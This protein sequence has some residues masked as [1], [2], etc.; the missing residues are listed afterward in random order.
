LDTERRRRLLELLSDNDRLDLQEALLPLVAMYQECPLSFLVDPTWRNGVSVDPQGALGVVAGVVRQA[1]S[2]VEK[3]ATWIQAAVVYNAFVTGR[4]KV[5]KGSVLA[6][7]PEIQDY[8]ETDK[9]KLLASAVRASI[10][11]FFGAARGSAWSL[12]FWRHGFDISVCRYGEP[13]T[14]DAPDAEVLI[15]GLLASAQTY[16]EQLGSEL[17]E[18]WNMVTPDLA[19]PRRGEVL[20]ALLA[21]QARL[22]SAIVRDPHLWSVDIGR[23]TLRCMVDTYIT[24]RWLAEK[25]RAADFDSFVEHGL[26]NEKLLVEHLKAQLSAEVASEIESQIEH[27]E[28]WINSQLYTF[29]LPVNIG[30]WKSIRQMADEL[31]ALDIY[32]L[33]FAPYSANI[34]GTWNALARL[35]LRLCV[36]PLHGLHR[37]PVFDDPGLYLDTPSI[38]VDLM[39]R[40]FSSWAEAMGLQDTQLKPGNLFFERLAA[41]SEEGPQSG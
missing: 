2:R 25:G 17:E 19:E 18:Q 26:G 1:E 3:F 11:A 14:T 28:Q 29:L 6:E 27:M 34:H 5:A 32:N 15:E 7:F 13:N 12:Y 31:G 41:R 36:N 8:P 35:N 10:N 39:R 9:S 20:S 37:T 21:R 23:I 33:S 22:S 40:T 38:A 24:L 16:A 4:L 30:A